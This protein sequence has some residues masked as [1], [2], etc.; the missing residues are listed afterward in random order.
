VADVPSSYTRTVFSFEG[1]SKRFGDVVAL[2]PLD[3]EVPVGRTLALIGE[4][5]SGKSTAL[6]LMIGLERP[7]T[8]RVLFGG[9]P[10]APEHVESIRRRIG[11]VIQEGGLFP[12]L[13]ARGN[14]TLLARVLGW[15]PAAC[16][17]RVQTLC[18]LTR[19][20][21]SVLDR[22]PGE[23]SGGQRQRVALMRALMLDPDVVLLD[24]PLGALD[25]IIRHEL[26]DELAG[27]FERLGKTVVLVTHD[28]AEAAYL[29]DE[30]V[31]LHE[32]RIVQAG[33]YERLRAAPADDYA[34][35]FLAA[36]RDLPAAR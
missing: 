8:G 9:E 12:H 36:R 26:Q 6:R 27:I 3:L 17:E 32:G 11:Y 31:L 15:S 24:E 25:P 34:A 10:V 14:A 33:S 19:L 30:L 5:G 18:E 7:D 22:F 4:S 35:R 13:T 21:E 20:D 2:H 28:L 29:A 23:I 1:V 16:L